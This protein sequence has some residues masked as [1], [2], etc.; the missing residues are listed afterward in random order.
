[1]AAGKKNPEEKTTDTPGITRSLRDDAEEHLA[2]SQKSS[3]NLKGQTP[4]ELIHELQVHQIELETQ[5][6]ELRRAHAEL[7]ESRNKYLDLYEFAPLGYL[8]LNN[9]ALV[10]E[11]NL[12][13]ATLLG[14]DQRKLHNAR[15]RSF[16]APGD[17]ETWDRYFMGVLQNGE[18]ITR[19]LM[20]TRGDGS[21]FPAQLES[22]RITGTSEGNPTVRVAFSDI[23]ERKQA[24][25]TLRQLSDRLSLATRAGGVGI[26]DYDVVNNTLTW[27]DQMFAL[28]GIK[29]E[30]FGGAYE[31][32][33]AGLHPGDK[34]RGDDE[35]QMALSGE[36]EFDSEFR[37]LWPDGNPHTLRA[38][39]IVQ[40]DAWGKPLRMIG[41]NWDISDR[42]KAEEQALLSGEEWGRTFDAVPDLISILDTHHTI[43]R[44]NKAMADK[45]GMTPEEV[46]GLTCYEHVHG[47]QCPPN[48]C[49]HA[50]LL[51]DQQEHNVEIRE[52]Q[53]GGDFL[54]T[55]TPLRDKDGQLLGS[56][57]VARDITERKRAEEEFR[58]SVKKYST[59]Y[60]Q[61][62]IAIELY[63]AAGRLVNANPACLDLFGIDNIQVIRNLSLFTDP[64]IND[65]HKKRLHQGETVQYQGPFDFEK[66]KARDLYPTSREGV[67][68]LDVL[69]TPLGNRADS[70]TGFLVQIQDITERKRAEEERAILQ[71]QFENA[72]DVGNLAWWEMDHKTGSVRFYK[73]KAE[74]LGY[75]P[76]QFSHYTDFTRLLHPDDHDRVMQAMRD[77]VTGKKTNYE[78]EYRIKTA[79]GEYRWFW[80]V[81]GISEY[82]APGKP[83]KMMGFVIDITERKLAEEAQVASEIRYR[84]LFETAQ[85]GILILDADTGQIVEVNPFLINMLGFSHEQFLGKKIW[86]IGLFKDIVANKDNFEELQRKEFIRYEDLPLETACGQRIAVEFVSSVYEVNNKKVIQCN[87]RNNTE[88]KLAEEAL[89]QKNDEIDGYFTNTLDLLFIADTD[90]HFRRLNREWESALGYTPAELKGKRFIDFVHPDDLQASLAAMSE[91]SAGK[92]VLQF[93]NRYRHRSGSYRWIEWRLFPA[94]HLIY[95]SARDV[96]ERKKM[97]E[98]VEKSLAEKET[99]LKEIHHR[100]KN[101]LQVIT[102]ILNL[103][104]RR[105]K[106]LPTIEALTDSQSRV[107]SMALIHEHL[108]RG[109]DLSHIN[110]ENYLR[111]LGAGLFDAYGATNQG[112]RFDLNIRDIYLDINT[113]IPLGLI[114]NELITNS[115]KY[116]FNGKKGGKI[117]ISASENPDALT[118]IVADDGVGM[119]PQTTEGNQKSLGLQ[120]VRSLTRQIH[121]TMTMDYTNGTMY[122]FSIPKTTEGAAE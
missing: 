56:V 50:M 2:R 35:V 55:C 60:D 120:L 119:P 5:A 101:N 88:R 9:K 72:M 122:V 20:L 115:L 74:M 76:E 12:T 46:V 108:Y 112:I 15:F 78:A 93:A 1:M 85:D 33:Q 44:V 105:T 27:D 31:A 91:L 34:Q 107:H 117:T 36:K 97:T 18:K 81:G 22:I 103:Q 7:E 80:D 111:A 62:P 65:E 30:Q 11:V 75:P 96:T 71:S 66:V 54:V 45:L 8:T 98:L 113:S 29:R 13:G 17:V 48:F 38:F 82:D 24:E 102:S 87:I 57:H 6:E 61:S 89:R 68:W 59:I 26:W 43:L 49:P 116:A 86:E 63:D 19:T 25:E 42:K 41:T 39:A 32:W 37:V 110:L 14:T 16:V 3:S 58:E 92:R 109:K 95:A 83:V 10:T 52:D 53:L 106:D 64:N 84:R 90:G 118:F 40:R 67:I 79:S 94:G 28:Y 69:I 77:H 99:L 100:V 47:S 21:L 23:T 121:G 114:S 73:K 70:I 104:I 51:K 4:E